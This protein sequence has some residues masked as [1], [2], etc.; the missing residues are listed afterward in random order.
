MGIQKKSNFIL[1]NVDVYSTE[2]VTQFVFIC[3]V[4]EIVT[5]KEASS[6]TDKIKIKD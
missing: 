2:N 1:C 4:H 3:F 5:V 6:L